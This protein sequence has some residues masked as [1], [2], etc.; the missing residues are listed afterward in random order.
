MKNIWWVVDVGEGFV[1]Q[2]IQV[3]GVSFRNSS[4]FF[5]L[6][7]WVVLFPAPSPSGWVR[8]VCVSVCLNLL[9]L[10]CGVLRK[11]FLAIL[12]ALVEWDLVEFY[13]S[14]YVFEF[15]AFVLVKL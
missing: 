14:S 13:I 12:L 5:Y 2:S 1:E 3:F 9:L 11:N 4:L 15:C 10:S 7:S 8:C 6:F